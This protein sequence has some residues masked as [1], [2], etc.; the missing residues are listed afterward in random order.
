MPAL[1]AIA[2][3]RLHLR[4]FT[5]ADEPAVLAGLAEYSV[6]Q[7]LAVVPFPYMRADFRSWVSS[8]AF[9]IASKLDR[10]WA[11][12]LEGRTIGCVA[13]HDRADEGI[14][15]GYWIARPYWRRG[16]GREALLAVLEFL[17]AE[18]PQRPVHAWTRADNLHS[19]GLLQA[20]G[21][22]RSGEGVRDYPAR[23]AAYPSYRFALT[24][25]TGAEAVP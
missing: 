5:A 17:R 19:A 16:F 21:F 25:P 8:H 18:A 3:D 1:P 9:G 14:E 7:W 11:V 20:C 22:S 23:G 2:T 13:A 10:P 15:V 6:V 12:T 24:A 4:A